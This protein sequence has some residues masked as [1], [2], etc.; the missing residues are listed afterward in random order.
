MSGADRNEALGFK[1]PQRFSD[2][3]MAHAVIGRYRFL[4]QSGSGRKFADKNVGA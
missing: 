4:A 2:R 1:S 3:Y